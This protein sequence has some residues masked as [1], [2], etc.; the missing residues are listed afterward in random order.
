MFSQNR[1]NNKLVGR[2]NFRSLTSQPN[3]IIFCKTKH[4]RNAHLALP[5]SVFQGLSSLTRLACGLPIMLLLNLD[6]S[7]G[8]SN[9]TMG[10]LV[11]FVRIGGVEDELG[12]EDQPHA[13]VVDFPS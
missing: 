5:S 13:L 8:L 3:P 10:T 7:V 2:E 11:D 1:P 9:G 6:S 4:S 12:D